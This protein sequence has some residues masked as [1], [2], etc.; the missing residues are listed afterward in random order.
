[1][2]EQA[3]VSNAFIRREPLGVSLVVAPGTF[4]S[5]Q[6]RKCGSVR[7]ILGGNAALLVETFAPNPRC[8][9]AERGM[10]PLLSPG[11]L[12]PEDAFF[13]ICI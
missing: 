8:L 7:A 9:L 1:M 10:V 3:C 4:P 13:S 11:G 6:A 12:M 2:P 5:L